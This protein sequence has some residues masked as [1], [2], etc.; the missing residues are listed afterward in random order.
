MKVSTWNIEHFKKPLAQPNKPSN[1][2]RLKNI[3]DEILQ[4]NPD[5]L[6]VV[7]AP[8]DLVALRNWADLPIAS[9][10]LGAKYKIP[11]IEGTD[12]ILNADP[13]DPRDALQDL[14]AMKG[15]SI[16]GNQWIWFLVKDGIF[17]EDEV[18]FQSPGVWQGLTGQHQWPVHYWGD[19]GVK[20]ASHWRHPQV[21]TLTKGNH[22]L[23]IIGAHLKSKINRKKMF[24]DNNNLTKEYVDEALRARIKLGTE[25]N[26][27][28]KYIEARF[29]QESNPRIIVCGDMNDG[30]GRKYFE[31]QYLFF[32]LISNL[33]GDV[34]FAKQFLN[35]AL[36]DY[37]EHLR[38]STEFND[39]LEQWAQVND[40]L[41]SNVNAS[42]DVTKRQLIDHILFTQG[43]VN[44]SEGA[45]VIPRSGKIEH[46]IH[47]KINSVA[48]S[49][50]KTSDHKP[51]SI[52]LSWE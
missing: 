8:G 27:I 32:D 18:K 40:P 39:R 36:F 3:S 35:H 49:N 22:S 17:G 30:V 24:D 12:D 46:T 45:S 38:W 9:G 10:G 48:K 28:R 47:D 11:T 33:Q 50:E 42:I 29:N 43:F 20:N 41:F 26:D 23:E 4:I 16:S 7:E 52:S 15:N 6:C 31:R 21:L 25:A 34:F 1:K 13:D 5:I 51:V 2:N 19:L 44:G 37:E 14:Y